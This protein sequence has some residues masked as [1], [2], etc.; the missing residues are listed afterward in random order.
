MPERTG[1]NSSVSRYR[2]SHSYI[3][4]PRRNKSITERFIDD[5]S[6]VSRVIKRR[7]TKSRSRALSCLSYGT[8]REQGDAPSDIVALTTI[9]GC[10]LRREERE[11]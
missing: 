2:F 3:E 6:R 7:V 8:Q 1:T 10:T 11:G 4:G 9:I 5:F